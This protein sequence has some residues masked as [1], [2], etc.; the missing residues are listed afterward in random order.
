MSFVEGIAGPSFVPPDPVI[1]IYL[2]IAVVLMCAVVE[3]PAIAKAWHCLR[4]KRL[5]PGSSHRTAD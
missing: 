1:L 3:A 5:P 4:A 2:C